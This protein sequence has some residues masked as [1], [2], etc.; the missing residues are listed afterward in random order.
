MAVAFVTICGVAWLLL[1]TIHDRF[2]SYAMIP[3][4][5]H[6]QCASSLLVPMSFRYDD[7]NAILNL[8]HGGESIAIL[9]TWHNLDMARSL[10]KAKKE[11]RFTIICDGEPTRVPPGSDLILTTKKDVCQRMPH[12]YYVPSYVFQMTEYGLKPSCLKQK[13]H[14]DDLGSKSFC[15]FA[16]NNCHEQFEGV[17]KRREFYEVLQRMSGGR[18]ENIGNC[19]NESGRPARGSHPSNSL[20][21]AKYKFVIAFESVKHRGYVSEKMT[22]AL[23]SGAVPIYWGADD[24]SDH[25]N[26]QRFVDF[27]HFSSAEECAAHVLMLDF[28]EDLYLDMIRKPFL[29]P[30]QDANLSR[31]FSYQT[32]GILHNHIHA[33][34]AVRNPGISR[35]FKQS[36]DVI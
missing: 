27:S 9:A 13:T 17:R 10:E 18:V 31:T 33:D 15:V 20:E 22:N 28:N 30:E 7:Q 11:G 19:Y 34:L 24:V 35:L 5:W 36:H 1:H 21:F 25:F 8:E 26:P 4:P 16:Y 23:I 2:D 32:G 6:R 12:A 3:S 29:T 14:V